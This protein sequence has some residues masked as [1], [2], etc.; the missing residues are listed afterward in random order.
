MTKKRN[1]PLLLL[2]LTAGDFS[3]SLFKK[4]RS[5]HSVYFIVS[6]RILYS[7]VSIPQC[8]LTRHRR[9]LKCNIYYIRIADNGYRKQ[10]LPKEN[11]S[12]N[13]SHS[14]NETGMDWRNAQKLPTFLR[15]SWINETELLINVLIA[16]QSPEPS[17]L[18]LRVV[19]DSSLISGWTVEPS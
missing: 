13:L 18:C 4:L 12:H 16:W 5:V 2:L 19:S 1:K 17:C 7:K 11:K 6:L 8:R 14:W 9:K 3:Y 10:K 15:H